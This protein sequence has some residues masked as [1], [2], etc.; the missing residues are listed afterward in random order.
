[1]QYL[2]YLF[3][4]KIPVFWLAILCLALFR[5]TSI[6]DFQNPPSFNRYGYIRNNPVQGQDLTGPVEYVGADC[7]IGTSPIRGRL[8][9]HEKSQTGQLSSPTAIPSPNHIELKV[10]YHAQPDYSSCGEA[11]LLMVLDYWGK[12]NSLEKVIEYAKN[13]GQAGAY[14][15]TCDKNPVCTSSG[16]LADVAS[17]DYEMMVTTSEGWTQEQVRA[18][19][20]N[21]HPII[22]DIHYELK[23]GGFGHFVVIYGFDVEQQKIYYHDPL[24]GPNQ[25]A[26]WND[27]YNVGWNNPKDPV[28]VKDPLQPRG[29]V[30][31][32]VVIF[33]R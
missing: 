19:L 33:P 1:M 31:N 4:S 14:D 7:K 28:D 21:G 10:P 22:A 27:F 16:T 2:F 26:S 9:D 24:D 25:D 30:G 6:P 18:S 23:K 13:V 20:A 11:S 17:K 29:H 15:P 5:N 3:E 12:E 32:G 8:M